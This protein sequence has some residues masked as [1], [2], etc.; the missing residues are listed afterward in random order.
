MISEPHPDVSRLLERMVAKL[1]DR[2]ILAGSPTPAQLRSVDVLLVEPAAESGAMLA[3]LARAANPSVGLVCASVA[4]P[5]PELED[6]G[7]DFAATL[8]KPF[9]FEQLEVAIERALGDE[10]DAHPVPR[11]PPHS[12]RRLLRSSQLS[13]RSTQSGAAR[14]RRAG[15]V[16]GDG[17]AT[18][19]SA[20]RGR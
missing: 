11:R 12:A 8:V 17:E 9:T 1:G 2:P 6:L 14:A 19:S 4:A 18:S 16:P 15:A 10:R 7:I 13:S 20:R 3:R 5:P